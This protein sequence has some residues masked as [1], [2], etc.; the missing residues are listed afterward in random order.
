M[1]VEVIPFTASQDA[2]VLV[3]IPHDGIADYWAY[4]SAEDGCTYTDKMLDGGATC[5]AL[6]AAVERGVLHPAFTAASIGVTGMSFSVN[7]T[8]LIIAANCKKS[9]SGIRKLCNTI[10]KHLRP[11]DFYSFYSIFISCLS[12]ENSKGEKAKIRPD[13][14]SYNHCAAKIMKG[15]DKM[16]IGI[17]GKVEKLTDDH[18]DGIKKG[19]DGKLNEKKIESGKLR[20]DYG[21]TI[22]PCT[23]FETLDF[24]NPFEAIIAQDYLMSIMPV[25]KHVHDNKICVEVC[26]SKALKAAHKESKFK[27]FSNNFLKSRTDEGNERMIYYAASRA[28]IST[29]EAISASNQK[30]SSSAIENILKKALD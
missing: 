13:R 28:C 23:Q 9:A 24:K 18:I 22:T 26:A 25:F 21:V 30:I 12:G 11:G 2:V 16:S 15:L 29:D 17:F 7:K 19:A 5:K 3:S 8:H 20:S 14:D 4:K 27:T 1:K 10:C 6:F